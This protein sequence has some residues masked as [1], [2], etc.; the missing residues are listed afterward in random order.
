M[1]TNA[2]SISKAG[3]QNLKAICGEFERC[4]RNYP[5]LFHQRMVP[6]SESG[7]VGITLSQWETFRRV[8]S[9]SLDPDAWWQWEK[10]HSDDEYLGQWL[11]D[12]DGMEEFANLS[13]SVAMVLIR[14]VIDFD[15]L[16]FN[17]EV[18]CGKDW[19]HL[20]HNWAFKYQMPLLRSDM[21]LW[22][23]EN[24]ELEEFYDLAGQWET[25]DD[26]TKF[27]RHPVVWRLIDNVFSSSMTALR[28]FLSTDSVI[29]T[30]EPWPIV[31]RRVVTSTL[32]NEDELATVEIGQGNQ[33]NC[34]Q[35]IFDGLH[36]RIISADGQDDFLLKNEVRIKHI[37]MLL[38]SPHERFTPMVM[39]RN[40][41]L[42]PSRMGAAYGRLSS[43]EMTDAAS[44]LSVRDSLD[45]SEAVIDRE[46]DDELRAEYK[47]LRDS[48][49][50]ARETENIEEINHLEGKLQALMKQFRKDHDHA[51]KIRLFQKSHW[52]RSRKNV[53][54]AINR[55]IDEVRKKSEA[56]ADQVDAQ[57]DRQGGFAYRPIDSLPAWNVSRTG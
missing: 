21:S 23:V 43:H 1:A 31:E 46:C 13:E 47:R 37:A 28:A 22:G 35:M 24:Y 17:A 51:G 29:A 48:L 41:G 40:N 56:I 53:A 32:A 45:W 44:D 12:P 8:E 26:G 30:N 19:L 34:H 38:E 16:D 54:N 33:A 4:S 6:W 10:P 49:D 27:P 50:D 20:L 42:R 3:R 5:P 57:I 55:A 7:R 15:P 25:Q 11:G 14:E 2:L 36:W 9:D 39:D 18:N 52:E